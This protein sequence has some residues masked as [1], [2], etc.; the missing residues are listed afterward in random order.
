MIFPTQLM[1][2][3]KKL[4]ELV[5]KINPATVILILILIHSSKCLQLLLE[6]S[7]VVIRWMKSSNYTTY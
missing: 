7:K 3:Y 4:V 2:I 1:I 5:D 6:T